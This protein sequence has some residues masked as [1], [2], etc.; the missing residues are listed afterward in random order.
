MAEI[1]KYDLENRLVEFTILIM[2]IVEALP[3]T[4]AGNHIAGQLI[5]CGTSP[6]LNYSEAQSSSSRNDFINKMTICLKELRETGVCLKIISKKPLITDSPKLLK[7]SDECNQL[8]S[9]FVK[10]IETA[11]KNREVSR[12]KQSFKIQ[13]T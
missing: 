9:I 11:E 10:S 4:R 8:I 12:P 2:E 7:A 3:E 5:R 1:I 13:S 6:T